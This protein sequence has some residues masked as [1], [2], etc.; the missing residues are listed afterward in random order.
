MAEGHIVL[1][2]LCYTVAFV[3]SEYM[4]ICTAMVRSADAIYL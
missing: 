1:N 3:Q 2:Q 4:D